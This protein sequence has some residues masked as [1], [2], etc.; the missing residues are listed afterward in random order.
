MNKL[1]KQCILL[2][3]SIWIQIE[4]QGLQD[5]DTE[6]KLLIQYKVIN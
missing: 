4:G 1:V 6:K 2:D 5:L 3:A